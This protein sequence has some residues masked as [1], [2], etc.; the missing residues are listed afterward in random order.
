M[1]FT[2]KIKSMRYHY[3]PSKW[4]YADLNLKQTNKE[5]LLDILYDIQYDRMTEVWWFGQLPGL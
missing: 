3:N 4:C 5:Q 2:Q 1:P